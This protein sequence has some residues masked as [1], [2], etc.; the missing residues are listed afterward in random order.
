MYKRHLCQTASPQTADSQ[1][2]TIAIWTTKPP[3]L[4]CFCFTPSDYL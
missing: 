2:V 1:Q 3:P 4:F